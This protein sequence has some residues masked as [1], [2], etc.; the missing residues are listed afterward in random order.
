MKVHMNGKKIYE[1]SFKPN[2]KKV[3]A[4]IHF[5]ENG[6][7]ATLEDWYFVR[8]NDCYLAYCNAYGD[9]RNAFCK[10]KLCKK[11]SERNKCKD[12]FDKYGIKENR[13]AGDRKSKF[14]SK[15]VKE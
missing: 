10:G 4:V 3:Y 6:N 8:N 9:L 5:H 15:C 1:K 12:H 14:P 13:L 7:S 11:N 2:D